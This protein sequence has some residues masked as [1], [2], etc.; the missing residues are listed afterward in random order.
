MK[1]FP[2]LNPD[3]RNDEVRIRAMPRLGCCYWIV[4][5]GIDDDAPAE[6]RWAD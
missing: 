1:P 5:I 2:P 6:K 3:T 4:A